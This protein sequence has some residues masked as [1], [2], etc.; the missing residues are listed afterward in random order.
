MLRRILPVA[1][2]LVV[3]A[4]ALAASGLDLNLN[5]DAVRMTVDFDLSNNL[6]ADASWLHHQDRGN[7]A[8]GG[9]HVTGDATGG[10]DPV[11]AG[12]GGRLL[13]ADSSVGGEDDGIALPIG[14]FVTYT[15][16][17]YNRFVV[18]GSVYYAPDVLSF[19]DMTKYQEFN[20]WGGYSVLRQGQVYLG[21]RSIKAD[22]K[23]SPSVTFDTGLH[24]G[25]RLRF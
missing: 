6:V 24:F 18:G 25:L 21:V 11:R 23:R 4:P 10:R 22:F 13:W 15:I 2:L 14:G 20:A 1:T 16:P 5:N 9:L 12:L 7:V 19:G 3:S 8:G 17:Q